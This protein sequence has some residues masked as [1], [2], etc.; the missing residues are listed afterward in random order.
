MKTP[1]SPA[2]LQRPIKRLKGFQR[3]TVPAGQTKTVNIDISCAD[4]WF[5]DMEKNKITY[6]QGK[7]VFEIGSSSKDIKGSVTATMNG[8]LKPV[9]KTVVADCETVVLKNGSST[10][11]SVTAAMTDD[12]FYDITKAGVIYTSNN[13][14]V[15]A[16]DEKGLVTARGT[17]VAT[18]TAH[19]TVDNITVSGSF[20]VKVMPDLSP[21]SI[22][23]N[24]TAIAG[25]NPATFEYNFLM[26]EASPQAPVVNVTPADPAVAVE[27]IQAKGIPGTASFTLTDGYTVDK[28][29]YAVNF[30]IKSL[31]DEFK[32]GT[33]DKQWSWI[34]ENPANRSLSKKPGSL[35][36]T[37]EKGDITNSDN[38]AAN[39]LLQ[40]ANTD[41]TIE[42]KITCSGKPS[43]FSQNAGILAYQDDDHFVKLVY[44][45]SFGRRGPATPG[46][47][48]PGAVQLVVEENGYQKASI[49]LS[50]EGIIKGDNTLVIKMVKKGNRYTAYCS[51]DGKKFETVGT[52][53]ILLKDIKAG[54]IVCDGVMPAMMANF[55]RSM[56]QSNQTVNPFE[57]AFDYFRITNSGLK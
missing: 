10:Q 9:L 24:N 50:M 17:G 46:A 13:P 57:V 26:K 36:I 1:E 35:V 33:L 7:Y 48:Q 11:T 34:R 3:V 49:S 53:E 4:L 30:G 43:G 38:N 52:A 42:S 20:P 5:W 27:T 40:S 23:V 29:E 55:A 21:A 32:S 44:G 45:A 19:V 22:L 47:E 6:D 8:T 16:V 54:M 51:S 28:K 12:S 37:S 41:W 31:T 14:A 18:I 2:S 56:P 15:A 25:F 39:I